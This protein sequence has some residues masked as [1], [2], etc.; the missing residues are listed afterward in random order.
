MSTRVKFS[1]TPGW[2]GALVRL[3]EPRMQELTHRYQTAVDSLRLFYEGKPIEE[4]KPALQQAWAVVNGGQIRDPGLTEWAEA[5][6]TGAPIAVG[7]G[8]MRQ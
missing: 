2:E 3:A 7:Y 8:G 4:I 5:I 1:M 6:R